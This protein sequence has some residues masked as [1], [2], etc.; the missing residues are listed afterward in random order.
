MQPNISTFNRLTIKH[1][2]SETLRKLLVYLNKN[3]NAVSK[4][5]MFPVEYRKGNDEPYPQRK[6]IRSY[7]SK[8]VIDGL[9]ERIESRFSRHKDKVDIWKNYRRI[10]LSLTKE[11]VDKELIL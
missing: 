7:N 10:I 2:E 3:H 11:H 8:E 4:K 6:E 1:L 9:T 5:I